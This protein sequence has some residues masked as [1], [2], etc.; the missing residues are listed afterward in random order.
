[1]AGAPT[2]EGVS[3]AGIAFGGAL[4]AL[5]A[6]ERLLAGGAPPAEEGCWRS[7]FYLACSR[8]C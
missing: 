5:F 8:C 3:F 1:M 7:A 2:P 4:I 6:L